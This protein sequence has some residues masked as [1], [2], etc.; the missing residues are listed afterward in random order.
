MADGNAVEGVA[1]CGHCSSVWPTLSAEDLYGTGGCSRV[2]S[3]SAGGGVCDS[4]FGRFP[5]G[6]TS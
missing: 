6:D 3:P 2:D 5:D 1:I 4:L